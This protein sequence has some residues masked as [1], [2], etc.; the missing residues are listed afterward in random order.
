M[1]GRTMDPGPSTGRARSPH[2]S[3]ARV[4][5]LAGGVALVVVFVVRV[6]AGRVA[7]ELER[8]GPRALWLLVPYGV[9]T[10]IGALPFALLLPRSLRPTPWALI[11]GRFAAST[12]NALLPFFGI[13][14]EP[15]RLLWLPVEGQA[16]GVAA[17]VI[18]RILYNGA[19]GLLL[20][21]GAVVAAPFTTLP[22]ELVSVGLVLG[23]LT[24]AAT[25]GGLVVVAR[26]GVGRRL[27]ALLSRVLGDR[28]AHET[29][30][31]AVDAALVGTVR[32]PQR[33]LL[34][35]AAIHLAS[36]AV[37]SLEVLVGLLVLGVEATPAQAAI[38]AVV[39]IAVSFVFSSIPSQ[40][41]VQEGAQTL[42]AGAIGLDPTVV[43][44]VVLL[45]RFRQLAFALLLPVVLA[46]ARA[47]AQRETTNDP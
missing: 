43:L 31:R 45:Q 46:G 18:D 17:I 3:L 41:G 21:A 25:A 11:L 7:T 10:V 19:N 34:G 32:G 15:S 5:L 26:A 35:G 36:R 6:G 28:Y 12:A 1:R 44:A 40:I 33:P 9:G 38:L 37:L 29:F 30:G 16:R 8:A 24:L 14:G 2:W 20:M 39:P 13:L 42:I 47:P 4:L 27:H 22:V 23:A